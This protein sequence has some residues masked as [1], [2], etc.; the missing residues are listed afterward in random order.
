MKLFSLIK[1]LTLPIIVDKMIVLP[2]N[3]DII[4][5]TNPPANL[6]RSTNDH[7]NKIRENI[8]LNMSYINEEYFDDEEYGTDWL[9]LKTDFD[10]KMK[11]ICP[12]FNS[13][14]IEHKAGRKFNYDYCVSFLDKKKQIISQAK[15]EFKFNASTIDETPQFVS[16]MKPSQYLSIPFEEYYYDNYLVNLLQKFSLDVPS[17]ENY[18][19]TIHNNKPKCMEAAQTL[20]Y[21]GCKQSSKYTGSEEAI[22]FY[23]SCNEASRECIKNFIVNS[24]LDIVKLT[25]YLSES[26]D[27]K[28]YLL[29]KNGEFNVELSNIDDYIIVNCTK[30]PEKSRF[31]AITKTGKKINILLRWKNG[32]GI[33]Y[34][35]FQI[36]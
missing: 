18:L 14:K 31:E 1:I 9:K 36:S 25:Q 28:I 24:E 33:A 6:G 17:R 21:Q 3:S 7:N 16:P 12:T 34:P 19:K 32:N 11:I 35:A 22:L 20:Y 30:N 27:D 23:E 29:Y 8:V 26:Q 10:Q 5:F 2:E 13:Y 15:L 4:Y